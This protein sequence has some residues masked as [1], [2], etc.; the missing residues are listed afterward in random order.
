MVALQVLR[1]TNTKLATAEDR[2][3]TGLRISEAS[4]DAAY[5]SIAQGM[6]ATG[7][8]LSVVRDALGLAAAAA[9]VT[10]TGLQETAEILSQVRSRLL[11]AATEGVDL[12]AIQ[13]EIGELAAQTVA[14]AESGMFGGMNWLN[15]D[16]EDIY[17][18]DLADRSVPLL[19]SYTRAA[20]G[21]SVS[22][23]LFDLQASSLFNANGGGILQPD[24][25]SPET[26]GGVRFPSSQT[27]TGY[28]TSNWRNG[29]AARRDITFSGPL[30]FTSGGS[31]SF[32]LT[33]DKDNPSHAIDPPYHPG[34]RPADP[35][36]I[37]LAAVLAA[38]PS[39]AGRIEDYVDFI[40]VLNHV[41]AGSGASAS[42]IWDPHD[43]EYVVNAI[44]ITSNGS[45]GLDGSYLEISNLVSDVGT[46]GLAEFEAPGTRGNSMDLSFSPFKI[47]DEVE[48]A[49][50]FRINGDIKS[51]VLDRETVDALLGREDG[52]I[53]TADDMVTLLEATIGQ[54]GLV[55]ET[56]S[57]TQ[58]AI[59]TDRDDRLVGPRSMI[60][61]TSISVNIEPLARYGILDIDV[62]ANPH[63]V[64]AYLASVDGML[65]RALDGAATVGSL[66]KRID[67][68]AAYNSLSSDAIDRG[69]GQL[70]DADMG[71]VAARL[72][73][74]QAQQQLT[75]QT[76]HLA[77]SSPQSVLQLFH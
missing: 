32:E 69:I 49:F 17:E 3:S 31:I 61:F 35:I 20:S 59:H 70:V 1:A 56:T 47:Y 25:R 2:T 44:A 26:I 74:L 38:R 9:D 36:V 48:I 39:S 50:D 71:K 23:I 54:P 58:I 29:S 37:D 43:N 64:E 14:I 27:D 73:A 4:Q 13:E 10:Y 53:E 8:V 24:S 77:N 57:P 65:S 62:L 46:G 7:K 22:H 21:P 16:V 15:T 34:K 75:I 11:M 19:S 28:S 67:V 5:W 51:Y 45:T 6:R 68:Q 42:R 66:K 40:A 12:R 76:L 30:D 33:V 41:L 63:L 72:S 60:G 55:I 52:M 18:G